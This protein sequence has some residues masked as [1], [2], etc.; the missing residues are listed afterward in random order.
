M[1][2]KRIRQN[3]T[4]KSLNPYFHQFLSFS[5]SEKFVFSQFEERE[6]NVR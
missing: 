6:K 2:H 3:I 4:Q 5:N 1:P